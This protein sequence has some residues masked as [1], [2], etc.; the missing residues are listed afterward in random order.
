MKVAEVLNYL[1]SISDLG[2]DWTGK[3]AMDS[4]GADYDTFYMGLQLLYVA[5]YARAS[6]LRVGLGPTLW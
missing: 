1:D 2:D 5:L 3:L 6:S 4:S